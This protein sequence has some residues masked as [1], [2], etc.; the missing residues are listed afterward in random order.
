MCERKIKSKIFLGSLKRFHH[1]SFHSMLKI[2]ENNEKKSEEIPEVNKKK[3]L[4]SY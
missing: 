4:G 3:S 1:G 2:L